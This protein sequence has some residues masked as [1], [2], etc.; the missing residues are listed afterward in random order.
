[1]QLV[2]ESG[3][4]LFISAQ[5]EAVGDAQRELIRQSLKTASA[6]HQ[7]GEP[8]DWL[9]HQFPSKWRL[10]NREVQFNWD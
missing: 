1:M 6:W 4:P 5:K 10:L 7:T 9:V 3:T 2:A 8:L